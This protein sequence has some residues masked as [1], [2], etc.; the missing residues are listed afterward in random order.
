[1]EP[2]SPL[3]VPQGKGGQAEGEVANKEVATF[4]NMV[5]QKKLTADEFIYMIRKNQNDHYN[6]E[7]VPYSEIIGKKIQD[8]YT[9][10]CKGVSKFVSSKPTEFIPV[11]EWFDEVK[12]F[13]E[14]CKY[15]FFIMFRKWKCLKK[16]M[17]IISSDKHRT[18]CKV[19]EEK[20]FLTNLYYQKVILNHQTLCN[21]VE[22]LTFINFAGRDPINKEDLLIRKN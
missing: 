19:L 7:V 13:N 20:M 10:S 12:A 16:W 15:S 8:Y 9:F 6:M 14:I 21:E 18:V 4:F 11:E 3:L 2:I 22:N 17:K 1:M 5:R